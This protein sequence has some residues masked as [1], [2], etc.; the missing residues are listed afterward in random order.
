MGCCRPPRRHVPPKPTQLPTPTATNKL[1]VY[2]AS[3]QLA[4]SY[5]AAYPRPHATSLT[6]TAAAAVAVADA[7]NDINTS[8]PPDYSRPTTHLHDTNS[9]HA[10]PLNLLWTCMLVS[11]PGAASNSH[12]ACIL[13]I[14]I[15]IIICSSGRLSTAVYRSHDKLL[16]NCVSLALGATRAPL[17]ETSQ[18]HNHI[19]ALP[20]Q[21]QHILSVPPFP[22]KRST[23][24]KRKLLRLSRACD[25]R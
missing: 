1:T 9:T 8:N 25:H 2:Q 17:P 18:R 5:E 10:T 3:M 11:A 24:W 19:T 13:T 14:V 7:E 4:R 6:F 15:N 21:T 22:Y 20:V 16:A 23:S 12:S